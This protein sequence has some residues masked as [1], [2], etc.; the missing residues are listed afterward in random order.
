LVFIIRGYSTIYWA[1]LFGRVTWFKVKE[2][3]IP[4]CW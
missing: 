1:V 4:R 3:D 2:Y